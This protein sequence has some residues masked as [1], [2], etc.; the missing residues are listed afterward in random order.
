[1]LCY[2]AWTLHSTAVHTDGTGLL[3]S[4]AS[5]LL[6]LWPLLSAGLSSFVRYVTC[7]VVTARARLHIPASDAVFELSHI[8]QAALLQLARCIPHRRRSPRPNKVPPGKRCETCEDP[9]SCIYGAL[10]VLT[11]VAALFGLSVAQSELAFPWGNL[12]DLLQLKLT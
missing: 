12:G 6:L 8:P 2:P 7:L 9:S 5:S 10:Q 11:L 4:V 3:H 1:M